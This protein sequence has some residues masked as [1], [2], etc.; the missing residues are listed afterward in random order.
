[1]VRIANVQQFV[2]LGIMIVAALAALL[3]TPK[4]ASDSLAAV[5]LAGVIPERFGAWRIDGSLVPVAPA[6]DVQAKLA[7]I[8]SQTY[9]RTYINDRGQRVMLSI[10]YGGDQSDA[11]RVHLPEVCYATQ[12]F[13]IHNQDFGVVGLGTGPL[14]VKRLVAVKG[15]RT[16]PITY[17]IVVGERIARSS[18]EQKIAQLYYGVRG[19]IP[20]GMLVRVSTISRDIP[21]SYDLQQSFIDALKNGLNVN[22]RIRFFGGAA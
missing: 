20:D 7:K 16:E 8:Y 9:A 12:G 1:M 13:A 17:W 5:P 10:A 11:M 6:P 14:P 3:M 15:P 22:D 19:T 2:M 21:N 18:V 4:V